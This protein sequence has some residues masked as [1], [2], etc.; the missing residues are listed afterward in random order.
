MK[1]GKPK[2]TTLLDLVNSNPAVIGLIPGV[3]G[4]IVVMVI[5]VVALLKS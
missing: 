5:G 2:M 3:V 4:M 1:K